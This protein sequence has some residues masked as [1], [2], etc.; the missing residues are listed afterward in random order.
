MGR[1]LLILILSLLT[2]SFC[3][4]AA[5]NNA[6]YINAPT[7]PPTVKTVPMPAAP[8]YHMS[9]YHGAPIQPNNGR[10][11]RAIIIL[12]IQS[13]IVGVLAVFTPYVYTMHPFTVG[14]LTRDAKTGLEKKVNLFIYAGAL[15]FVFAILGAVISLIVKFTGLTNYTEHW[16]YNFFCCRFFIT[17]SIAFLGGFNI[18]LPARLLNATMNKAKT[19]SIKGI[20]YMALTLPFFSASS[21]IPILAVVLV[22]STSVGYIGPV[23]GLCGVGIGLGLPFAFPAILN[24][25]I[26]SKTLLNNIQV[27]MGF[28]ALMLALKFLSKADIS[29]GW[30]LIDRDLFIAIWMGMWI[31]MGI[32]MLGFI[33]LSKDTE[34]EQNLYGQEYITLTRLFIAISSLVFAIYLLPGIWGAPLRGVSG[35]LPQ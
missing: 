35:F 21:T 27:I 29:L 9:E 5:G 7:A 20:F 34:P 18:K 13:L 17:L 2:G 26:K 23:I 3:A 10:E 14:Y 32:Y 4:Y 16:I 31:F 24:F 28:S 30:H 19:N 33:S 11:I 6:P 15:L 25:F 8:V 22:L 1:A 12:F